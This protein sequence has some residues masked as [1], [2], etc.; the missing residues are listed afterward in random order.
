MIAVFLAKLLSFD[1]VIV[2]VLAGLLARTWWHVIAGMV[3]AAVLNEIL[4]TAFQS[5]RYFDTTV[6]LIAMLAAGVWAAG[7]YAIRSKGRR[8][9][10]A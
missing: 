3:V 5:S 7:V 9:R 4:L 6:L 8:Q 10:D 2:S 1:I